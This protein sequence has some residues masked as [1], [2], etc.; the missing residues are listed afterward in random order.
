MRFRALITEGV[1]DAA[2]SEQDRRNSQAGPPST[3]RA[4]LLRSQS[5]LIRWWR[6]RR[7]RRLLW[8]VGNPSP[9]PPVPVPERV[10]AVRILVPSGS[11]HGDGLAHHCDSGPA[12]ARSAGGHAANLLRHI[13]VARQVGFVA[14]VS[15]TAPSA[16]TLRPSGGASSYI[17]ATITRL[18]RSQTAPP[19]TPRSFKRT[20][21]TTIAAT[22]A[23]GS[24]APFRGSFRTS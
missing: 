11:R 21:T 23:H 22:G 20:A 17:R 19:M 10:R 14:Q 9:R 3:V 6:N 12:G 24:A 16:S 2:Q 4:P 8:R 5:R 15:G 1:E 7:R 13:D 18:S